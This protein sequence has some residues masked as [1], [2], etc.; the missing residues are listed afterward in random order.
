MRVLLITVAGMSRRFSESMGRKCLKCIYYENSPE[1]TLLYRMVCRDR[2]FDRYIIVGGY[3]FAE[4]RDF[5]SR[6][7]KEFEDR[8]V[9]L[10]N[11]FYQE[12]GSGYSLYLGLREAIRLDADEVVF[13]EGDLYVDEVGFQKVCAAENNVITINRES[14][15]AEK[16]VAFYYDVNQK[17]HY[18]YDTT[19][20]ILEIKEPF[21]GIFNSGQIWKFSDGRH[22]RE[23]FDAVG[24]EE[25][26]GTNLVYIQKYFGDL[27]S[28]HYDFVIFNTWI[29]CNTI[30]DFR[31]IEGDG[32]DDITG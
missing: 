23:S 18:I 14:I 22:M 30:S 16:A 24:Q 5:V 26:Q 29:N 9:L 20:N 1:E 2:E 21:A 15:L 3:L 27:D 19:H 10:E 12:Y 13:A 31:K 25:W 28:S 11:E 7:L 17:I 4:L 8:I 32:A 6:Y